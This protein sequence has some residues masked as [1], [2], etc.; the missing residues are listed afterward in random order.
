MQL[1]IGAIEVESD[2]AGRRPMRL[3]KQID[4]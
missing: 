4:E 1:I 3:E 2:L